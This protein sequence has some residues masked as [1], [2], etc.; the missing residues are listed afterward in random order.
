MIIQIHRG[1][2]QMGGSIIEITDNKTRLFFDIGINLVEN[3]EIEIPQI[4]GIFVV[5]LTVMEFLFLIIIQ[6]I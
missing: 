5:M 2:N 1:Q 3:E 6:T 4:D